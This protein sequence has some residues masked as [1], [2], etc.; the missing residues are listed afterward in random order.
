MSSLDLYFAKKMLLRTSSAVQ[1]PDMTMCNA[2]SQGQGT[3]PVRRC[4]LCCLHTTIKTT[5]LCL[6]RSC[7][8]WTLD[9]VQ[10]CRSPHDVPCNQS[11]VLLGTFFWHDIGAHNIRFQLSRLPHN[12]HCIESRLCC[13]HAPVERF[14]PCCVNASFRT[15]KLL[16]A[17]ECRHGA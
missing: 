15:E 2:S 10:L 8:K 13:T 14:C 7:R 11:R 3:A 1:S 5:K 4:C 16:L 6:A 17:R 12:V 9:C